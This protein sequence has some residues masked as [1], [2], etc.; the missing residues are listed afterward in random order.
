MPAPAG[1]FPPRKCR[2]RCGGGRWRELDLCHARVRGVDG[3]RQ[4]SE[5]VGSRRGPGRSAEPC[6]GS[7]ARAGGQRSARRS[8]R[9]SPSA[10]CGGCRT[11]TPS[12]PVGLR[13]RCRTAPTAAATSQNVALCA[14][15]DPSVQARHTR[16]P[17]PEVYVDLS[18]V[19]IGPSYD[20]AAAHLL[21]GRR[22]ARLV[23]CRRQEP[24]AGAAPYRRQCG[25]SRASSASSCS[26]ASAVGSC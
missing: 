24:A 7:G 9:P 19:S 12:V 16:P 25:S 21:S 11:A 14:K 26:P 2:Q 22:R 23:Q 8:A 20:A 18:S 4:R 17:R 13:M 3:A 5:R 1:A 6:E 15:P 10:R